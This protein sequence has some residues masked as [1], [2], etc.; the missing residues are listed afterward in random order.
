MD[1]VGTYNMAGARLW[2]IIGP[3]FPVVV[4]DIFLPFYTTLYFCE[5]PW[6]VTYYVRFLSH[7]IKDANLSNAILFNE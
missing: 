3:K 2:S 5:D 6:T 1:G 7:R 4:I